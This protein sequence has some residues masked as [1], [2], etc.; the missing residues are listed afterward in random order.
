MSFGP[1]RELQSLCR[2]FIRGVVL[3]SILAGE[4]EAGK[5]KRRETELMKHSGRDKETGR[6]EPQ[7]N[8]EEHR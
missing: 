1:C 6:M 8:A 7:M 2:G 3:K 4:S 5:R